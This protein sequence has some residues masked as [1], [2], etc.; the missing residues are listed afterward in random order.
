MYWLKQASGT[1]QRKVHRAPISEEVVAIV[2][3]RR[4]AVPSGC[5]WLFPG[6]AEDKDQP[7]QDLRRFWARI[8]RNA[9]LPRNVRIHDLRHT[10]ASLVAGDGASLLMIGKLL[11]HTQSKTT[12]RYAHLVDA[13]LRSKVN[14]VAEVVKPRLRVVA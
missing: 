7:V 9:G 5:E 12:E 6:D 10:F 1:K 3:E 4:A 11:G 8:R 13:P 14:T 2:R